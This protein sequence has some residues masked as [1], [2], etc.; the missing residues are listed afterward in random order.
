MQRYLLCDSSC[1]VCSSLAADVEREAE[2]WLT[3]RSLHDQ[4]IQRLLDRGRPNWRWEPTLL[5]V[6]GDRVQVSTGAVL[7]ARLV[8]GVG[9]RRASRIARLAQRAIAGTYVAGLSRRSLLKTAGASV[10]ALAGLA[11]VPK[12]ASAAP[13]ADPGA[14]VLTGP[15][16]DG[17]A[18]A[19]RA[20]AGLR[21]V[22]RALA[23]RGFASEPPDVVAIEHADGE[24]VALLF[25]QSRNNP[26]EAGAVAVMFGRDGQL[27]T[28]AAVVSGDPTNLETLA[29]TPVGGSA[30]DVQPLG[31]QEYITCMIVCL[32]G[33]CAAT[34]ISS[35]TRFPILALVLSC[36]AAVCG[37]RTPAC[38]RT[39]RILW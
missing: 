17:L 39:C 9:L 26:H 2:G 35:C 1:P 29:F 37:S 33:T 27:R 18:Q 28:S 19:A 5:T 20:Q 4:E 21:S 3:V 14:T 31:V 15:A 12:A 25:Y 7:A 23:A 11:F 34:A 30:G 24:R 10:A 32:G 6:D 13:P 22:E 36:I 16:R 38:H 8:A